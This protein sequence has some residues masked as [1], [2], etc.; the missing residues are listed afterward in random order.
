MCDFNK[1]FTNERDVIGVVV[2]VG[3]K[4]LGCDMFA[5][6]E[7][8]EKHYPNLLNSYATE[9]ITSGIKVSVTND[10]VNSYLQSIINNEATQEKE[11]EEKGAIMKNRGKKIHISTFN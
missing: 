3:D 8:F 6:H 5:T 7:I 1:I 2:V 4:I 10:N 11:V 9:A